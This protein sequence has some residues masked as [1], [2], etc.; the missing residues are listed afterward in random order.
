TVSHPQ[1]GKIAKSA[2]RYLLT[3]NFRG[4]S[5]AAWSLALV[6]NGSRAGRMV[7]AGRGLGRRVWSDNKKASPMQQFI[8]RLV[9]LL[10]VILAAT[11]PVSHARADFILGDASNY[12]ILFEGAGGNQP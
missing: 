2:V 11:V 12:G 7:S 10:V 1:F 5:M 4:L 8:I 3:T 9:T 6:A